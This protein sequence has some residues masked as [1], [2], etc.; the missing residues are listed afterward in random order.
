MY[1]VFLHMRD[2]KREAMTVKV[3]NGN[4]EAAL[5]VFKRKYSEK[6]F[7]YRER[8]YYEKPSILRGKAKKSAIARERKR[9]NGNKL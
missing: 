8:R 5:R 7:E 9:K 6:V 4:V 3:R 1:G 2:E